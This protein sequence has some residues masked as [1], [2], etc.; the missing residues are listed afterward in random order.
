MVMKPM[1]N[2]KEWSVASAKAHLSQVIEQALREGP[3][4]ITR[5]GRNA[6]VIVSA[7]EWERKAKRKGSLADFFG[8]SPL[9]NSGLAIERNRETP[10]ETDL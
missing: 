8:R 6:V 9:R 5:N 10:R 3:Q 2:T 1:E 7:E 4:T